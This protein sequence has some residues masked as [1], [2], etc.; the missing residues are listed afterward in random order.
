MGQLEQVIKQVKTDS[1][2]TWIELYTI[3]TETLDLQLVMKA[4]NDMK[5]I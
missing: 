3:I 1:S 2:A 5:I 4:L